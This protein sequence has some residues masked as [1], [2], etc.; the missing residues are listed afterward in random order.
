MTDISAL[1][2]QKEKTLSFERAY[3]AMD[4]VPE[5]Q[6]GT[7]SMKAAVNSRAGYLEL[8]AD[9]SLHAQVLCARCATP[10]DTVFDFTV[11]MPVAAS[12]VNEDDEADYILAPDGF[13][14]EDEFCRTAAF[15]NL[16]ARY[17][18]REDCKGLCPM[19][20]ADKN[21]RDCGCKID[22]GANKLAD[23]KKLLDK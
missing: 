21:E 17:L 3:P 13:L 15:L 22:T 19:C 14:D 6:S 1:I 5:A 16:P 18:C 9:F 11:D 23:L 12:L 20:G 2:A 8:H 4:F 10:F 7:L